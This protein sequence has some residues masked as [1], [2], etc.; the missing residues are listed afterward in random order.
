LNDFIAGLHVIRRTLSG[1]FRDP[2]WIF[3]KRK[4][5]RSASSSRQ[6]ALH[7]NAAWPQPIEKGMRRRDRRENN[8]LYSFLARFQEPVGLGAQRRNL[9]ER[10]G[11][12]RPQPSGVEQP[13][14]GGPGWPCGP[15]ARVWRAGWRDRAQAVV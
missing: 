15:I 1:W 12:C 9:R 8:Y 4:R 7:H 5:W 6:T 3:R 14:I 11:A 13:H 10:D 2:A